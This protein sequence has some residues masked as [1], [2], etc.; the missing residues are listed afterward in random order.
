MKLIEIARKKFR[1]GSRTERTVALLLDSVLVFWSYVISFI[2]FGLI[3]R[4]EWIAG[5]L[6]TAFGS[7][8]FLLMDGFKNGQGFGKKIVIAQS[9]QVER[10]QTVYL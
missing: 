4:N 6:S 3:T 9:Y 2:L 10:W 8:V 5:P 7:L 1:L